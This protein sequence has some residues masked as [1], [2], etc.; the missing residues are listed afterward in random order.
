[1]KDLLSDIKR[2]R[3][4][5]FELLMSDIDIIDKFKDIRTDY[6]I[7][8]CFLLSFHHNN[9]D[10]IFNREIYYR[11]IFSLTL[12]ET[13]EE[14]LDTKIHRIYT[15]EVETN[16]NFEKYERTIKKNKTQ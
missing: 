6:Y 14:Y 9:H 16:L 4:T 1:M 5:P 15:R 7:G 11:L 13:M 12:R 10:V 2:N 8:D 3:I